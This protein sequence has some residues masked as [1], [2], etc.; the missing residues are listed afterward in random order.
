MYVLNFLNMLHN[1]QFFL[2]KM[3][4]ILNATFFGPCIIRILHT[5]CAKI[6]MPNSS[7]K[8]F[9]VHRNRK[10][11]Y[12]II[13]NQSSKIRI[14]LGITDQRYALIIISLF[15]TQAPTCFGTY[16]PSSGSVLYPCEL[17]ENPKWLCHRDVPLYCKCWWPVCTGCCS[18]VR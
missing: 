7:A 5:G 1:L 16:V 10:G 15:I 8:R 18:F 14:N 2:F 4:F 12:R 13:I 6:W 11:S 17:L 9:A 3:P